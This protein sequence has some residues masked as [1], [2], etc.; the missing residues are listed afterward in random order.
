[1]PDIKLSAQSTFVLIKG[2]AKSFGTAIVLLYILKK[3]HKVDMAF[4]LGLRCM[5]IV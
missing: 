1:M 3:L 5:V 4:D 2:S